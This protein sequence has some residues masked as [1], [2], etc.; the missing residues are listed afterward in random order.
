MNTAFA[1]RDGEGGL[2]LMLTAHFQSSVEARECSV[3]PNRDY[4]YPYLKQKGLVLEVGFDL[5]LSAKLFF[6]TCCKL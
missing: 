1:V 2:A 3:L 6:F 4:L 5:G